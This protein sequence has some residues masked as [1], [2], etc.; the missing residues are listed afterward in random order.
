MASRDISTGL[1]TLVTHVAEKWV[2]DCSVELSSFDDPPLSDELHD[3]LTISKQV[4]IA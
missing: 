3:V 2:V 4:R 1:P